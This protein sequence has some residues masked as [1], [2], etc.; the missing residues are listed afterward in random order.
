M[1]AVHF[2]NFHHFLIN[3]SCSLEERYQALPAFPANVGKLGGAWERGFP[4]FHTDAGGPWNSPPQPQFFLPRNLEIEYIS[5]LHIT[6]RLVCVI[7]MFGNFVP[8]CIRSDL[9][10]I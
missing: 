10:G 3:T 1:Q 6:E 7:K 8:D 2:E 9:R 5:Y 4:G